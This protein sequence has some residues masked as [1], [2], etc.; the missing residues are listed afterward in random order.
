MAINWK[1]YVIGCGVDNVI[2]IIKVKPALKGDFLVA[3]DKSPDVTYQ[4]LAAAA[5][6]LKGLFEKERAANPGIMAMEMQAA[7]GS[8]LVW[9]PP[10]EQEVQP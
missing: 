10:A 1:N 3:Q 7:D 8:K 4:A 2:R 5:D 9:F 6:H